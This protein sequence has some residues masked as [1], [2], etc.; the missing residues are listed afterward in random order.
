MR[1]QPNDMS[2]PPSHDLG[3]AAGRH[4]KARQPKQ[5]RG[6]RASENFMTSMIA[7]DLCQ[8]D[9]NRWIKDAERAVS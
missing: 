9:V 2:R 5:H 6:N 3:H 1:L 7:V 4:I 8:G